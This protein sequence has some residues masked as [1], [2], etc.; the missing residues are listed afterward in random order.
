LKDALDSAH[1]AVARA[2]ETENELEL[3]IAWRTLGQVLAAT[4]PEGANPQNSP[5]ERS[6][7]EPE[8]CFSESHQIFK[9]INA[10]S[11]AA[12]TL[13]AWAEFEL[14]NGRAREGRQKLQEAQ[15]IFHRLGAVASMS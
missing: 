1:R 6:D 13:R 12:R 8:D 2:R 5:A 7:L 15:T 9:K 10:E 14:Q 4:G 11:E 3:G